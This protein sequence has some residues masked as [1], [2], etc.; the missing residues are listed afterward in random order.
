MGEGEGGQEGEVAMER[1]G[2]G[3]RERWRWREVEMERGG[4]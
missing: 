1:G 3:E 4:D 2:D